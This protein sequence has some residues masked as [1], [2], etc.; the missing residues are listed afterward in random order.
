MEKFESKLQR[1]LKSL[2]RSRDRNVLVGDALGASTLYPQPKA[3]RFPRARNRSSQHGDP[4]G[5]MRG[6]RILFCRPSQNGKSTR[7][8]HGKRDERKNKVLFRDKRLRTYQGRKQDVPIMLDQL[9]DNQLLK[10][11]EIKRPGDQSKSKDLNF[12]KYHRLVGHPMEKCFVLKDRIM[13]LAAQGRIKIEG[14]ENTASS[15]AISI[16]AEPNRRARANKKQVIKKEYRPKSGPSG[17]PYNNNRRPPVKV[18]PKLAPREEAAA[19]AEGWILVTRRKKPIHEIELAPA[20]IK[21]K[22]KQSNKRA[23]KR[24]RKVPR[25]D[26]QGANKKKRRPVTLAE[27]FS[28]ESS[29]ANNDKREG[30]KT[31]RRMRRPRDVVQ[32]NL[33]LNKIED[34]LDLDIRS[35]QALIQILAKPEELKAELET[36]LM[37]KHDLPKVGLT[38]PFRKEEEDAYTKAHLAKSEEAL[39]VTC[40]PCIT[41]REEDA[42]LGKRNHNRPLFVSSYI[43]DH[44][45]N[46]ILNDCGSAVNI[47]PIRTMKNIGLSADDLS[48]SSL[49][50]QGFNQEGQRTLGMTNL[51]L[52]IGDIVADTPLQVID[53]RTSYNLLLGRPWL[54]SNGVVPSTLNQCFTYWENGEQKTVYADEKPIHRSRGILQRKK[55]VAPLVAYNKIQPTPLPEKVTLPLPK[56]EERSIVKQLP[57]Q[58]QLPSTRSTEGFD[59]NA[60]RLMSR[61]GG[62]L[63][64]DEIHAQPPI[65]LPVLTPEQEKLRNEGQRINQGPLGLGYEKQ[66][67]VKIYTNR[68][69]LVK[70][71][72]KGSADVHQVSVA[73]TL[74]EKQDASKPVVIYTLRAAIARARVY[75]S[76]M[77]NHISITDDDQEEE[78]FVLK[79]APAEFEEG[80]QMTVD[81]LKKVDLGIAEDPRPTF[82]SASL[83]PEEETEYMA[84]L[85]EYHDIF[86]WNYTEM[87]GLDPRVA[88]HK[89]AFW[90]ELVPEIEKEVDKLIATNFIWEVKYPSW[91]ANIIPVKKKTGQIRVCVDFRDLNKACPKDNFPLPITELMVDATTGHEALSF[92]DGSSGHYQIWMDPKDEELTAFR[93]LKGIFCY[94]VMPFGLKNADATYQRAMQNIFDDFLHKR[95]E[96]YVDDLVVKTKQR[97][98]HL[99]DLR[100]VFERLRRFQLKMNP[101][102]CAFGVTSGKFLGFIV[103]HTG[104][105]VD[106]SKIDAIQKMP[107]PRNVSELKSFQG[108][109]AYIR[110]FISNLAG[111]CQ[112][113]SRLL[114]KGTPFVWDDSCRNA[115][116]NIKAYLTKPPVLVAPIV[117]PLLLYIAAQEKSVGALLA[118]CDEDNKERSLYYLSRTLVGA[119]LNYTPI[120]KTCLALI[121]VVQK[122]R[123]YLL[124]HSTK[125]ISR[126]D[127][128]KYIMSRPILS[129]R[130]AKWALVLSEF[131]IDFVPQRAI[132]GQALAN[133]LVDHPVPA[134]WELSEEFPDEEIFLVEVLPP[135]EM[136]FNGATRRSGAG[137]RVLFILPK[138]DLLPYSFMLTQTCLN[139]EAEYQA[140]LL[141]LGMAV[142]MKLPQLHIYGNSALVIKQLS[143]KFEVKKPELEPFW[144]QA[145]ELL[146]L[147]P[148]ASLHFVPHSENGPAD[149]LAGI[150]ARLALFDQRPSH[151]PI[152]ERWVI[153]PPVEEE[154]E[155]EL[156][157][158]I[159]ESLPISAIDLRERVQIRRTAPRYVFINDVLYRRSYEGLLLLCLSKEEGLQVLKETHGGICGAHQAGPKLHLQVKRLGYYWPTMLRDAIEIART[160]K[161]C[162]LH[163]DYIHQP[164]V[165]LH[166]TVASWPFEAWAYNPTANG[167]AEAF[168]KTLC[169]ILKKTVGTHKRS[170]DEKLPEAL[171]AYRMT[172]RTPTQSTPF[173]LVYGTGAVLP[174]EVQLPSLR[175]AVR[176]GLTTE[177]CAQLR[178]AKLESL[179]EQR[180]EAQQRLECYQ[181]RMTRAFNKKVRLRSFQKG[182]LVLA[183][184]RPMLFTRKTGGKFAPKWEGPYVVQEVYTNGVYKL[185]TANGSE[186]SITNVRSRPLAAV[187]EALQLEH[188]PVHEPR[189]HSVQA[190]NERPQ[191]DAP[192]RRLPHRK[193]EAQPE[194]CQCPHEGSQAEHP[195]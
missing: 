89:L 35:R 52:H 122:L 16:Q 119:E 168:N 170:W 20:T 127:P 186:L 77:V 83:T 147:I 41:F 148:E 185:V 47:L 95:V 138:K 100:A 163:A 14:A 105:E 129:G 104:I 13:E 183:G 79:E 87:S 144:R 19:D 145:G 146:A 1:K 32:T 191:V 118:Q 169:K 151:I 160:C 93:T 150:V 124:A 6:R 141:G 9:L 120:E 39:A 189:P 184:R 84:L 166:P 175:I 173:S 190:V 56:L 112:P 81:E 46:R 159:E 188:P 162:Q 161:P 22:A 182:D 12:C 90:P 74:T 31:S 167:L 85:R 176:E 27:F 172:A 76:V 153:P 101:L 157:E 26:V 55:G 2:S 94:K 114:K 7:H 103:H 88:L 64:K 149:A 48:P 177:E 154:I 128:L 61:A 43:R 156:T 91:I 180:L 53:S 10:L 194:R 116:K 75:D 68:E 28:K 121:F 36:L 23:A 109:L 195:A 69:K 71:I 29:R 135:W 86:A 92:M 97:S 133:F 49:L 134:E 102:K 113:F 59:P 132:K 8:D 193:P 174:L 164:P 17:R 115:F 178:L 42:Q 30:Q 140:I 171:W 54:H 143:G 45:I 108:H 117:K 179:D 3:E 125:L 80:G 111:R 155:E 96:C 21:T 50:I 34:D 65:T 131:E 57:S 139:N 99:L 70:I 142:E 110:R 72:R 130:L 62:N 98:Y 37:R 106:Q 33:H 51:K 25:I 18:A 107:E 187:A 158:E 126:A 60:Y 78:E 40:P 137:A 123:H 58:Q 38:P 82:L 4:D 136:Y 165:P 24:Q 192:T 63:T 44:K 5:R 181:S 11:P 15:H 73:Q 152:C 67:P 66:K